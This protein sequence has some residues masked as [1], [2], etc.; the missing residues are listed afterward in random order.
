MYHKTDPNEP[1]ARA[2]YSDMTLNGL[3]NLTMQGLDCLRLTHGHSADFKEAAMLAAKADYKAKKIDTNS[4]R[5]KL[6][7]TLNN[8][9]RHVYRSWNGSPNVK[10]QVTNFLRNCK[11]NEDNRDTIQYRR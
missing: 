9:R 1:P 3:A 8:A 7:M 2:R 11:R 6:V 10:P 4:Y 5:L